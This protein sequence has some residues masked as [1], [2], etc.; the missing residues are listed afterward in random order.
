LVVGIA[1]P[2]G[3][4]FWTGLAS[5][6]VARGGNA[7]SGHRAALFVAGVL[8]GSIVWG[9]LLSGLIGWGRRW[10]R[11]GFFRVVNALCALAFTFF[12]IRLIWSALF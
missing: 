4:P 5:D 8:L 3:L 6:V 12:A 10:L 11:P 7:L 2:A 1:N 9:G